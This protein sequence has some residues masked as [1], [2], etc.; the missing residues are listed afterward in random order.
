MD[1]ALPHNARSSTL[2]YVMAC[3]AGMG[4]TSNKYGRSIA[5]LCPEQHTPIR[6]GMLGWD[7][8]DVALPH[9]CTALGSP[10]FLHALPYNI[11]INKSSARYTFD[12]HGE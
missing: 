1:A 5:A 7:G 3:M 4:W 11:N 8:M 12:V 10:T 9:Y 6:N 2:P